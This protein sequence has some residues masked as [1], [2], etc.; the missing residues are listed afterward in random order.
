MTGVVTGNLMTGNGEQTLQD[1]YVVANLKCNPESC[2][3]P[4]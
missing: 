2:E 4:V 1:I 3:Y